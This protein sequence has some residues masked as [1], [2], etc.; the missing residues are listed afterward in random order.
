MSIYQFVR[1]PRL[2]IQA[3]RE[4]TDPDNVNQ[5]DGEEEIFEYGRDIGGSSREIHRIHTQRQFN[6]ETHG[7]ATSTSKTSRKGGVKSITRRIIR[8]TT[9]LTRGE[10]RLTCDELETHQSTSTSTS[11]SHRDSP[12]RYSSQTLQPPWGL[13][14]DELQTHGRSSDF[15]RTR[16]MVSTKSLENL[17]RPNGH[18]VWRAMTR[19]GKVLISCSGV[20]IH[21]C[22]LRN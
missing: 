11:S 4:E 2:F 7:S 18:D 9:T 19:N 6:T 5:V 16:E 12:Q 13:G 22:K 15:Q 17:Q 20:F 3:T 1:G 8:K 21:S 14:E 10:E